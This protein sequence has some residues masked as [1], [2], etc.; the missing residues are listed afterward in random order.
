MAS[1]AVVASL[2]VQDKTLAAVPFVLSTAVVAKPAAVAKRALLAA[3]RR[4]AAASA[5]T[6]RRRTTTASVAPVVRV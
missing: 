5:C 6:L 4:M 2:S 1:L 3:V